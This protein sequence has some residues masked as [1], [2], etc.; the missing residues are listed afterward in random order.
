MPRVAQVQQL[1]NMSW[2][3]KNAPTILTSWYE[4]RCN[5]LYRIV[6]AI[7]II[8]IIILDHLTPEASPK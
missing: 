2:C 4:A 6:T 7:T 1:S 8:T 3:L 5:R